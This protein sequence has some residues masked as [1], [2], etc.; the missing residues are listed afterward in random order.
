[1]THF[2]KNI[3]CETSTV[4]D[5]NMSFR[6]GMKKEVIDNRT[7]FLEKFGIAPHEHVAMCCDHG[8]KI[9]LVDHDHFGVGVFEPEDQLQSEVL[10]TQRKHLALFLLTADCLPLSL[11]DKTTQTIALAHISRKTLVDGLIQKT[12]TFLHSELG[13]VPQNLLVSIGPHIKK[14]S[15]VFPLPLQEE[16]A[17]LKNYTEIKDGFAH[18]DLLGISVAQLGALGISK[19]HISVSPIDTGT[20]DSY[21][22]YYRMKKNG[23]PNAARMAT[24]LMM[25]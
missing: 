22:S 17:F 4:A 3:V 24:I 13:V 19:E 5:G 23:E 25:R 21:Y 8:D 16:Q 2:P 7:H 12:M 15:Y 18:I 9:T 6:A 10:V 11:Y 20:S 14:E 1:M